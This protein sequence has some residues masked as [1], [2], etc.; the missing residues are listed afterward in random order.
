M[1]I[2][3]GLLTYEAASFAMTGTPFFDSNGQQIMVE[4]CGACRLTPKGKS[5]AN[6]WLGGRDLA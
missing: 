2:K 3:D 4:S 5:F 6:K 1:A